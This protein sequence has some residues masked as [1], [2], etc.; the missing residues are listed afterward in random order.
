MESN[1]PLEEYAKSLVF[2]ILKLECLEIPLDRTS[3]ERGDNLPFLVPDSALKDIGITE[4][5][6]I[7]DTTTQLFLL[8]KLETG[9]YSIYPLIFTKQYQKLKRQFSANAI[10]YTAYC[11]IGKFFNS[12]ISQLKL[13]L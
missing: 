3:W 2:D 8:Q 6:T 12:H 5:L 9:K 10:A 4:A 1:I 13:N 7:I 11:M